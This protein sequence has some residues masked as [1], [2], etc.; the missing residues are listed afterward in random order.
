MEANSRSKKENNLKPH[1]YRITK[2]LAR[3]N[4]RILDIK[5]G[6]PE[7]TG[8][9]DRASFQSR[10]YSSLEPPEIWRAPIHIESV[11]IKRN[12]S[13]SKDRFNYFILLEYSLFEN[14]NERWMDGNCL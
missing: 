10:P 1:E 13:R 8:C 2:Y 7:M 12:K 5:D 11:I 9:L 3:R 4:L 14:D 6:Q